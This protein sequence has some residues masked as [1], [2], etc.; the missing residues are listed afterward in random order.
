MFAR[1]TQLI[2]KSGQSTEFKSMME[3]ALSTLKQQAG[4]IDVLA[5]NSENDPNEFVG[6]SFW[7]SKEDADKYMAGSA[8]QILQAARPL[9]QGE[10]TIRSFNVE[11][12]TA[13]DLGI[14]RA[15]TN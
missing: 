14:G 5:L 1:M 4:C 7:E 6:I 3:R 2:A 9:L 13:H 10:P 8:Q 11:V 12:S 15:A